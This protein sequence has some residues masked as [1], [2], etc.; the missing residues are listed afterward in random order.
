MYWFGFFPKSYCQF[1]RK[2]YPDAE[3]VYGDM[4]NEK[5]WQKLGKFDAVFAFACFHHLITKRDQQKQLKFIYEHLKD[6][7][8]LM[9]VVWNFVARKI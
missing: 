9:I 2:N 8:A 3:F 4:T 5:V 1:A 6:N 7:G